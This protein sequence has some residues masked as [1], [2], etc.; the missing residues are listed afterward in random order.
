MRPGAG[1]VVALRRNA[2]FAASTC[3]ARPCIPTTWAGKDSA[4]VVRRA[5]G[6]EEFTRMGCPLTRGAFCPLAS[7]PPE[8]TTTAG[9]AQ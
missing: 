2:A 1:G 7:P 5:G 3:S 9:W 4:I 8:K 6:L